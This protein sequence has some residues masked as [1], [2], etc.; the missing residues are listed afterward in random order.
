MDWGDSIE[1]EEKTS[2]FFL[3]CA[4]GKMEAVKECVKCMSK[5]KG[6][7]R[8]D[9]N[10]KQSGNEVTALMC[11]AYGGHLKAVKELCEVGKCDVGIVDKFGRTAAH[12]ASMQGWWEIVVELCGKNGASCGVNDKEG[13]NVVAVAKNGETKAAATMCFEGEGAYKEL[14]RAVEEEDNR[15]LGEMEKRLNTALEG[16]A[17]AQAIVAGV[18]EEERNGDSVPVSLTFSRLAEMLCGEAG[19]KEAGVGN[20]KT[21]RGKLRECLDSCDRE[22]IRRLEEDEKMLLCLVC[23]ER[24]RDCVLMPCRHMAC[25]GVCSQHPRFRSC[26][27]C[28]SRVENVASDITLRAPQASAVGLE[29]EGSVRLDGEGGFVQGGGEDG[30]EVVYAPV[31]VLR[32]SGDISSALQRD[33]SSRSMIGDVVAARMEGGEDEDGVI[34][35]QVEVAP[36][37]V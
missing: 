31:V 28:L 13:R 22:V 11:A 35:A 36:A 20:L 15:R 2:A 9:V 1:G 26:P 27:L 17:E 19:L 16:L 21:I 32:E 25:C 29:R 6:N 34:T 30:G 4:G 12:F 37:R 8:Y 18:E 23:K 33:D 7:R 10:H 14:V 5:N 3:A 24:Q